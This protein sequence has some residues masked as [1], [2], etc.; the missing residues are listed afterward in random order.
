MLSLISLM[1]VWRWARRAFWPLA[2][3]VGL[4]VC[5]TMALRYHWVWDV[6]AGALAAWPCLR[7]GDLLL[8]RDGALPA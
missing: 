3:V 5:S 8:D 4:L 6:L 7:L 2:V 1:L